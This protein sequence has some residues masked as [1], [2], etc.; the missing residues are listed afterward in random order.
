MTN[1]SSV[2]MAVIVV[3]ASCCLWLGLTSAF[4]APR[5]QPLPGILNPLLA[6]TQQLEA[7]KESVK[8]NGSHPQMPLV[9]LGLVLC[10]GAAMIGLRKG[11]VGGRP[12]AVPGSVVAV[13]AFENELG[14]QAP[15]GFWDA[16]Y[17]RRCTEI[18]HGRISMIACIG[19]IVPEYVK[20]PG[21]C[22]TSAGI[23]FE[24]IPNGLEAL[25][26]VPLAGWAQ[27]F[28]FCGFCEIYA[29][30]Q[31]KED[32]PGKLSGNAEGFGP[33]NYGALGIFKGEGIS[34]PEKKKRS[35]NAELANGR[36][37]MFAIM[38][39]MFQNGVTGSTGLRCTFLH[40]PLKVS[41]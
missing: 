6:M 22:S 7:S 19:Y 41:W 34:D 14:V 18:K 24:T 26:K 13:H 39:M 38:G 40:P 35:L 1:K 32:P 20:F 23:K 11:Q 5:M 36:L 2:A 33:A 29:A 28:H 8:D 21:F 12:A 31:A 37:A 16:L 9:G 10:A 27:I 30:K 3:M 4:V 17:R 25:S 15:V